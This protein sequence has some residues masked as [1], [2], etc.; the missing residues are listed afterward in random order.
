MLETGIWIYDQCSGTNILETK[1]QE[2][3]KHGAGRIG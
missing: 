2:P 1:I 3:E